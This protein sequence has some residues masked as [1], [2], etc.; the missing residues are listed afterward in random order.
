MGLLFFPMSGHSCRPKLLRGGSAMLPNDCVA[1]Q[2][3]G[4]MPTDPLACTDLNMPHYMSG[5]SWHFKIEWFYQPFEWV[6]TFM[7]NPWHAA[8]V[9]LAMLLTMFAKE[10]SV[11][12]DSSHTSNRRPNERS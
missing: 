11:A 3:N 5:S 12:W 4:N 10:A 1:A 9:L 7:M 8:F 2:Y 6:G